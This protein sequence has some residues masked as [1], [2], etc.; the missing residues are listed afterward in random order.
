MRFRPRFALRVFALI[1]VIVAAAIFAAAAYGVHAVAAL[2]QSLARAQAREAPNVYR[3]ARARHRDFGTAAVAVA[4]RL[5]REDLEVVVLDLRDKKA[6]SPNGPVP[7]DEPDAFLDGRRIFVAFGMLAGSVPVAVTVPGAKIL[8]LPPAATIGRVAIAVSVAAFVAVAL[9]GL[10]LVLA[11]ESL[12]HEAVRALRDTTSAL[13]ALARRDFTPRTIVADER[14]EVGALARAYTDAA[15]GVAGALDERR[16]AEAEMQRF[17]AD[18]GHELRTPLTV[19]VGVLD[20]LEEGGLDT[21]STARLFASVKAETHR[22]RGTLEKL[23][24]LARL[25]VPGEEPQFAAVDAAVIVREV[26]ESLRVSA[27]PRE[28]RVVEAIHDSPLVLADEHDLYEAVFNCVENALKYGGSSDVWL[29]VR[30]DANEIE[31]TIRDRGPGMLP[32]DLE[33]AFERFY[34][35]EQTRALGGS[36]LGLAIVKRVVEKCAGSVDLTSAVERGTC[37]TLRFPR[38]LA[39]GNDYALAT[40][41]RRTGWTARGSSGSSTRTVVPAGELATSTRRASDS[42]SNIPRPFSRQTSPGNSLGS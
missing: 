17:I 5:A 21:A 22:M 19:V 9:V 31:L 16:S 28:L 32:S 35:G 39:A 8:L 23:I 14:S 30:A 15:A 7:G 2:D 1:F 37:V 41:S 3:R 34:R 25:G 29:G 26:A 10:A 13:H 27:R 33:R 40:E 4:R 6:Y 36:G 42:I 11:M 38:A 12:A 18:A 20:L 24:L